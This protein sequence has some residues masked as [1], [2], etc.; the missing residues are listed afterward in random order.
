MTPMDGR[1]DYVYFNAVG[2]PST[3]FFTGAI[4]NR[5]TWRLLTNSL[6]A[7]VLKTQQFRDLYGGLANA[8]YDVRFDLLACFHL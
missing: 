6:G 1:S 7:E 8:A 2:I 3:G 5:D 4:T